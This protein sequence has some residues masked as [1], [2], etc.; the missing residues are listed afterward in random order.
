MNLKLCIIC[1][2]IVCTVKDSGLI[3]A[4]SWTL[5]YFFYTVINLLIFK[6]MFFFFFV[7]VFLLFFFFLPGKDGC[8]IPILNQF[9][10]RI[11]YHYQIKKYNAVKIVM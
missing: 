10:S 8:I 5:K 7:F 6:T 9:V 3:L 2:G 4:L 1:F 11:R